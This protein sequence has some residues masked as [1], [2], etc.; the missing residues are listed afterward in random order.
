MILKRILTALR[1]RLYRLRRRNCKLKLAAL[2]PTQRAMIFAIKAKQKRYEAAFNRA[3]DE[4][5]P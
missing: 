5:L 3:K 2:T 4:E 1:N